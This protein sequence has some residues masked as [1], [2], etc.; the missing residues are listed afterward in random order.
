MRGEKLLLRVRDELRDDLLR[1]LPRLRG[2]TFFLVWLLQIS[3][4]FAEGAMSHYKRK[5]S[6]TPAPLPIH[7]ELAYASLRPVFV[8]INGEGLYLTETG[9][10][11][12]ELSSAKVFRAE[13]VPDLIKVVR[14][15]AIRVNV[16]SALTHRQLARMQH[17]EGQHAQRN[18]QAGFA[19]ILEML[20]IFCV[21]GILAGIALPNLAQVALDQRQSDAKD[22]MRLIGRAMA[23]VALDAAQIPP[24]APSAGV[25]SLIP[26]AGSAITA[27]SYT[28][29]MSNDGTTV[30]ATPNVQAGQTTFSISSDDILMCGGAACK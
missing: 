5:T 28:Y 13:I 3:I 17:A 25:S 23:T 11:S 26:A 30:T 2:R 15:S 4:R 29:S 18:G 22:H 6:I 14:A 12:A 16:P 8:L 27:G 7:T 1:R 20:I 24:V 21:M 19:M 10:W 9:G